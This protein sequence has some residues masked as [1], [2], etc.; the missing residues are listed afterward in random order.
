MY[1][2]KSQKLLFLQKPTHDILP[3]DGISDR[4]SSHH[5][6]ERALIRNTKSFEIPKQVKYETSPR[7]GRAKRQS[8][9]PIQTFERPLFFPGPRRSTSACPPCVALLWEIWPRI[10]LTIPI[11][12][13]I[14]SCCP[15]SAITTARTLSVS[16]RHD[17]QP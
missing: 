16:I 9:R 10:T 11:S 14:R 12:T 3:L 1:S 2:Y 13:P 5:A 4:P 15:R 8:S 7:F 6:I 17:P